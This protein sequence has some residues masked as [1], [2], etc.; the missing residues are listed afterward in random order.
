MASLGRTG[1][2]IAKLGETYQFEWSTNDFLVSEEQNL[3]KTQDVPTHIDG[4][5]I[6][7]CTRGTTKMEVNLQE[8]NGTVNSMIITTPHQVVRIIETS[9]NFR[10]RFI[11][12]SK[13]FL[14]ASNINTHILRSFQ[15]LSA[16]AIPVIH[17]NQKEA[18][19]LLNLF[20]Y[21]WQWF[22][23]TTHPSRKEITGHLLMVLLHDFEAIYQAQFQLVKKKMNRKEELNV[24]FHELLL[25]H[26]REERGVQFYANKLFVSPKYLTESIK[27]ITGRS[28]GDWI[29]EAVVLEAQ[30]LLKKPELSVQQVAN[31][32]NFPDQSTFGKLFKK[33]VGLTPSEYRNS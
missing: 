17:L 13:R 15:F 31:I 28:A 23:D 10:C 9:D 5:V 19:R 3:I 32:L 18:D 7:I 20:A 8:Y 4:Y 6:G 1:T 24:Q 25:R 21:I 26:F 29:T 33:E 2:S 14:V 30:T 11:V 16:N 12:F 27:E 22:Q